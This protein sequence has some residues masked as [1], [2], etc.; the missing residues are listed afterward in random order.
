[1]DGQIVKAARPAGPLACLLPR[2]FR[3][4]VLAAAFAAVEFPAALRGADLVE[5]TQLFRTGKYAECVQAA[6]KAIAANDFS[7]NYRLLKIRAEMEL[8]RYAD[9]L[10]TLDAALKRFP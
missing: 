9:A 2:S 3:C 10:K 5:A 6:E 7:E 4:L 8:G 1:M